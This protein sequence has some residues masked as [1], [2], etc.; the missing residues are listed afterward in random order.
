MSLLENTIQS[1]KPFNQEVAEQARARQDQLTKPQGSLGLLE[2]L[3]IQLAG[4]TG[5]LNPQFKKK[6]VVVM[7]GDHGVTAAGVSAFPVEVTPQMLFNMLNGGAGINVLARHVGAEVTVV[8][9]GVAVPIESDHP[10]FMSR[11]IAFGTQNMAVGPA[12]SREQAQQAIETGINVVN[13]LART[14]G[15][16]LLITGELGIGNTTPSAAIASVITGLSPADVTGRG[17]GVDDDGLTRKIAAIE[18]AIAV[19][20]PNPADALDVLAKVGGFEIGGIAGVILG[21][22]ALGVPVMI[23]GLISTA[24]ALIAGNL[25]PGAGKYMISG[26]NSVEVGHSAMLDYLDLDPLLDLNFRL[27]EGTGAALSVT[28][29]EAAVKVLNQMATFAE[30]TVSN[31]E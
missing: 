30:A 16:D 12:M 21:A 2:S 29:V 1:I 7:A 10:R 14:E 18:A 5:Q 3:S 23:D 13:H 15:A 17:T 22:A 8:D 28:I 4:I 6:H 9:I 20:Q 11:K 25:A 19:N 31:K 27:G 26:H 24:G